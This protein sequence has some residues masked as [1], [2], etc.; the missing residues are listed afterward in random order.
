MG[1]RLHKLMSLVVL[2]SMLGVLLVGCGGGGSSTAQQAPAGGA[3]AGGAAQATAAPAAGGAAAGAAAGKGV[4]LEFWNPFTGPDGKF[5]ETLVNRYNKE[6]PNGDTVKVTT[7]PQY[8]DKL[9]ASAAADTLPDVLIVH[10][11]Q[12]PTQAARS[13]IRPLTA[14]IAGSVQGNDYP[15]AVWKAGEYKG[16]RYSIPLDVHPLVMFYNQDLFKA[17]GI[18][19]APTNRAEFE[20]AAQKLTSG[21]N[22]GFAV[23]AGF[24]IMQEFLALLH[25]FGGSEFNADG[26]QVT[27]NSDA[28]VKALQ[29]LKDMQGKTSKPN[30]PVDAGISAF[31]Q[32]TN[33]VEWNGIWQTSNLTGE[34]AKFGGA[35]PIPT[36]GD[37]PAVWAGS[38]QLTLAKHK[39][40][41]DDAKTAAAGRFIKWVTQNSLEWAKGGQIPASKTVRNSAEFKALQP[42]ATIAPS[43]ETA[44]FPPAVP[45]IGDAYAELEKAVIDVMAGKQS[46]PKAALDGA[47][48]KAAQILK[49]NQQRYG[50]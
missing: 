10:A 34:G 19:K 9:S 6:N 7:V 28:G 49:Q 39:K 15:D 2:L 24:P 12:I 31:K 17:A 48:N 20:A 44:F 29:W 16:N 11:D 25:Q 3:P 42:E 43:I 14:D 21:N 4:A 27:W 36:I 13:V 32:G 23:T 8:Y 35:A 1:S 18:D 40:G 50:G 47:A 41:E 26:T 46:D 38:H 5:M 22:M 33:A 37:K 30:L 45:G